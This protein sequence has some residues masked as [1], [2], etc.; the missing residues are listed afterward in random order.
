MAGIGLISDV[1]DTQQLLAWLEGRPRE[2]FGLVLT[3]VQELLSAPAEEQHGFLDL[4]ENIIHV[5][6]TP[7]TGV[8]V[9]DLLSNWAGL[10]LVYL[11][12]QPIAKSGMLQA[13]CSRT[14]QHKYWTLILYNKLR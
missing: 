10:I 7:S 3:G 14:K 9:S 2:R 13:C 5:S 6:C 4:L 11:R 12:V 8:G 1:P